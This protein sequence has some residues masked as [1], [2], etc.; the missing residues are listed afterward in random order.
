MKTDA[1]TKAVEL[2]PAQKAVLEAL[3]PGPLT[4]RE[5]DENLHNRSAHKRL[6]ELVRLGVVR[7][8]GIRSCQYT[9]R[10]IQ[11]WAPTGEPPRRLPSGTTVGRLTKRQL[12]GCVA[13]LRNYY[14]QLMRTQPT[15]AADIKRLAEWAAMVTGHDAVGAESR[16]VEPTPRPPPPPPHF[17]SALPKPLE[18]PILSVSPELP[19]LPP[20]PS[21]TAPAAAPSSSAVASTWSRR[22][23]IS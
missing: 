4:G 13:P 21:P 11:T 8:H 18:R 7:P 19:A 17:R 22:H 6:V 2:S 5:L 12:A 16:S 10:P 15:A 23:R 14:L 3:E 9:G 20:P 1:S